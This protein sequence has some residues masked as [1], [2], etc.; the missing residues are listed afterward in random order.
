MIDR[1]MAS[2]FSWTRRSA[3]AF[4][5]LFLAIALWFLWPGDPR[6]TGFRPQGMAWQKTKLW[7]DY[8]AKN[9]RG[10]FSHAWQ[11]VNRL[12][13]DSYT[14]LKNAVSTRETGAIPAGHIKDDVSF[15]ASSSLLS[16]ETFLD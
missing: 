5:A 13:V 8:Y 10:L 3:L 11:E 9:W 2:R 7:R 14:Q 1:P 12:L 16:H 15:T 4:A 6:L